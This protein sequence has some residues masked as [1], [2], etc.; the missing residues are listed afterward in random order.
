MTA[1]CK[2]DNKVIY[3]YPRTFEQDGKLYRMSQVPDSSR[4]DHGKWFVWEINDFSY[5]QF[6]SFLK[7]RGVLLKKT[8][9]SEKQDEALHFW[10][11]QGG[12]V[13]SVDRALF[14]FRPWEE[15]DI[16]F[17]IECGVGFNYVETYY[18]SRKSMHSYL[19]LFKNKYIQMNEISI[20]FGKIINFLEINNQ[21]ELVDIL[22]ENDLAEPFLKYSDEDLQEYFNEYRKEL[23]KSNLFRGQL[24]LSFGK[25]Q[26]KVCK[27]RKRIALNK[28]KLEGLANKLHTHDGCMQLKS[29]WFGDFVQLVKAVQKDV[30]YEYS[31]PGHLQM[32]NK[33]IANAILMRGINTASRSHISYDWKSVLRMVIDQLPGTEDKFAINFEDSQRGESESIIAIIAKA[34]GMPELTSQLKGFDLSINLDDKRN[35][36]AW[37]MLAQVFA[38]NN[39]VPITNNGSRA[40]IEFR[41]GKGNLSSIC[42]M[43]DAMAEDISSAAVYL[44]GL[45]NGS[46][47]NILGVKS[48]MHE[49][50][51]GTDSNGRK[52][53][54]VVYDSNRSGLLVDPDGSGATNFMAEENIGQTRFWM[55]KETDDGLK[56]LFAKGQQFNAKFT[57]VPDSEG[58]L[59]VFS[60]NDLK[61]L[62]TLS[63]QEVLELGYTEEEYKV[64]LGCCNFYHIGDELALNEVSFELYSK[65]VLNKHFWQHPGC[66]VRE[67]LNA[68]LHCWDELFANDTTLP[69]VVGLELGQVKCRAKNEF[70][71]VAKT[72]INDIKKALKASPHG[73]VELDGD[74][75]GCVIIK[76]PSDK[77]SKTSLNFQPMSLL[78][79]KYCRGTS[80]EE[81]W[82]NYCLHTD[83]MLKSFSSSNFDENQ[84]A[85]FDRFI[86]Y[87][88]LQNTKF[89]ENGKLLLKNFK[90]SLWRWFTNFNKTYQ[91]TRRV[92]MHKMSYR[93]FCIV[94]DR[95]DFKVGKV[96]QQRG[97]LI[98]PLALQA[99]VYLN[100]RIACDLLQKLKVGESD[101]QFGIIKERI[102]FRND[103][104]Q[105]TEDMVA[106]LLEEVISIS[107][108]VTIT[109]ALVL[110]H[111]KD[112]ED[113]QGDDDGD[114]VTVDR[115]PEV[116]AMFSATEI[117]WKD[118]F[119]KNGIETIE[120]EMPKEAQVK[121]RVGA[122]Y[123]LEMVRS[124]GVGVSPLTQEELQAIS[125]YGIE[126]P[127]IADYFRI[128]G[129]KIPNILGLSFSELHELDTYTKGL[130][131][132]PENFAM[133]AC[134]LGSNPAGPIGA[135]SNCAPD[136]MIKA[137]ARVDEN[138]ILTKEG[139]FI[140]EGY[141][142]SASQVQ[143]SIDFA[144]RIV[145]IINSFLMGAEGYPDYST[146][147]KVEDIIDF[148]V[149]NT[150]PTLELLRVRSEE[151]MVDKTIRVFTHKSASSIASYDQ[152]LMDTDPFQVYFL[153]PEDLKALRK[154][155]SE[156]FKL[157]LNKVNLRDK[158]NYCFDF[159][160]IYAFA[161]FALS[162]AFPGMEPA[163][164]K[165]SMDEI[166][167]DKFGAV[168]ES[169]AVS[170]PNSALVE[171][172]TCFLN[173]YEGSGL[174]KELLQVTPDFITFAKQSDIGRS[175]DHLY[176]KVSVAIA[177]FFAEEYSFTKKV[178]SPRKVLNALFDAYGVTDTQ[179]GVLKTGGVITYGEMQLSIADIIVSV[180][181]NDDS[182]QN[183]DIPQTAWQMLLDE[184]LNPEEDSDL[185]KAIVPHGTASAIQNITFL[186]TLPVNGNNRSMASSPKRILDYFGEKL[187]AKLI[188]NGSIMKT[189]TGF[190]WTSP[191][192]IFSTASMAMKKLK[193]ESL[194]S[195]SEVIRSDKLFPLV[196]KEVERDPFTAVETVLS[197]VKAAYRKYDDIIKYLGV[198]GKMT[199]APV[200]PFI[201][202]RYQKIKG[203]FTEPQANA[204]FC[205]MSIHQIGHSANLFAT[206]LDPVNVLNTLSSDKFVYDPQH[207]RISQWQ[208]V[209]Y[210]A[211][212][213]HYVKSFSYFGNSGWKDP[214][215]LW[216]M[217]KFQ[218][219]ELSLNSNTIEAMPSGGLSTSKHILRYISEMNFLKVI[220]L[221]DSKAF[222]VLLKTDRNGNNFY[223]LEAM[224][225]NLALQS[226][227]LSTRV[228]WRDSEILLPYFH[229]NI[230]W[231]IYSVTLSNK[232]IEDMSELAQKLDTALMPY[233]L[234]TED[235]NLRF[236]KIMGKNYYSTQK[237]IAYFRKQ[238][239]FNK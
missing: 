70:N 18:F 197:A 31:D 188:E 52:I 135:P 82:A 168:K 147:L 96:A 49:P 161:G 1:N 41:D 166:L 13:E 146:Q 223:N 88:G 17:S 137:L 72:Q 142:N 90:A 186:N 140:F 164:W 189:D 120:L 84:K 171:N 50:L 203:G 113:M 7:E 167:G 108:V 184:Y 238:L 130:F 159:D 182:Y 173:Y 6:A 23:Y 160:S 190:K 158:D 179:A 47:E 5:G 101:E 87:L 154:F 139:R 181:R 27:F 66:T 126:C 111:P 227:G 134:K 53:V 14:M 110:M 69:W 44:L 58:N 235:C 32:C 143:I 117:F 46:N 71:Y 209:S 39:L 191:Q 73:V 180:A 26:S 204:V 36:E 54:T 163:I 229:S 92:L 194:S 48:S 132:K 40:L 57:V 67:L 221:E 11:R 218:N 136:L 122:R 208:A 42:R 64:L 8:S 102:A 43:L 210:I 151:L 45:I 124:N 65:L 231:T 56:G 91:P 109:D 51:N 116:V 112:V 93:G 59:K 205:G 128:P 201:N 28:A 60:V 123:L 103:I 162:I 10:F 172:A 174:M 16:I 115:D 97:P 230:A 224:Q 24:R 148:L 83:E 77:I 62:A 226:T 153:T 86:N 196:L 225:T 133:I 19:E 149:V 220:G 144:K 125:E 217:D 131:M 237:I 38:V 207:N 232:A 104:D 199:V 202:N 106:K 138:G 234:Q 206:P 118:F 193:S 233:G 157:K 165:T 114:T 79:S 119:A 211:S 216:L 219:N 214:K 169:F 152:W 34:Y 89:H 107:T 236:V 33:V 29:K 80:I 192:A 156:T 3:C 177:K 195:F 222:K 99:N 30:A 213:G 63:K 25:M 100:R 178:A 95:F 4:S 176:P 76:S 68:R 200:C 170:T 2:G 145:K 129:T 22:V 155:K 85:R 21:Q 150:A 74:L 98:S 239:A 187:Q 228:V 185:F 61:N 183:Q 9:C 175:L 81:V 15:S 35:F 198:L 127:E 12:Y 105:V 121:F 78:V 37:K 212:Q 215:T 20:V 55:V 75:F 94:D 141:K